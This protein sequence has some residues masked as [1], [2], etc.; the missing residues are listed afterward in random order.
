M[1]LR[2][3]RTRRSG[4]ASRPRRRAL[5]RRAARRA[6]RRE[7]RRH[8][9]RRRPRR[10]PRQ[11]P[12]GRSWRR[13]RRRRASA[14]AAAAAAAASAA[15]SPAA[16]SEASTTKALP[17]AISHPTYER[18]TTI[19][20]TKGSRLLLR[21]IGVVH[22]RA[23]GFPR[24]QTTRSLLLRLLLDL[25]GLPESMPFR[26]HRPFWQLGWIEDA[27]ALVAK[28]PLNGAPRF[29]DLFGLNRPPR[30]SPTCSFPARK[31]H[32]T[33]DV[34]AWRIFRY[35]RPRPFWVWW[36]ATSLGDN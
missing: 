14:V 19:V 7:S 3:K 31:H 22:N 26:R 28:L 35:I 5:S 6:A 12:R 30:D 15:S 1:T 32:T 10:C 17:V 13:Q 11:H 4:R 27:R 23:R 16:F 34:L 33:S 2:P 8:A 21:Q 24:A 18:T 20:V 36:H 29:S 9:R 25:R